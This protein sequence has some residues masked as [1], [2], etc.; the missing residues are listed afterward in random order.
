MKL[1][2]P[3]TGGSDFPETLK[4]QARRLAAFRCCYC[5]ERMG[6]EVHHLTPKEEGG[7]GVL[8]NA[9]LLCVQCHSDYGHRRDKRLQL[10]QARDQWY[11][12]VAKRYEPLGLDEIAALQDLATKDDVDGLKSHMAGLF[13]QLMGGMVRGSTSASEVANV[14]SSMV[15]TITMPSR[16]SQTPSSK[17]WITCARCDHET[18]GTS[19]FCPTYCPKCGSYLGEP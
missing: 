5:R 11:E 7:K 9:V 12:V 2:P 3:A 1:I 4:L 10:R 13:E 6:H 19:E 17:T 18:V 16:Y 8:D 15:N 14:G